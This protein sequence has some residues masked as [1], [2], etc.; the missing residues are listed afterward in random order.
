MNDEK[1][2]DILKNALLLEKRGRAFYKKAKEDSKVEEVKKIFELMENEEEKHI[3]FLNK[4]FNSLQNIGKFLIESF[5]VEFKPLE[6]KIFESLKEKIEIA[7]YESMAI[8]MAITFEKEAVNFYDE[9]AKIS[10]TEEERKVFT[11]LRDWEKT[12]VDF[13][14]K[15]DNTL[16]EKIWYDNKFWPI[17]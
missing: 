11:Y 16:K 12:H 15:I 13:L 6:E 14:T 10:T 3:E 17:Y 9:K 7:N 8:F 2:L 5:S 4:Q 1:I